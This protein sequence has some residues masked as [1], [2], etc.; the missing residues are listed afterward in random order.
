MYNFKTNYKIS[1]QLPNFNASTS[2]LVYRKKGLLLPFF[3]EIFH[4]YNNFVVLAS[5]TIIC[6]FVFALVFLQWFLQ[7]VSI[8]DV[9]LLWGN[10]NYSSLLINFYNF[11]FYTSWT[12]SILFS[13]LNFIDLKGTVNPN[14]L[15]LTIIREKVLL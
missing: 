8:Y 14:F 4:L 15:N 11:W 12:F 3:I 13:F 5:T 2:K 9:A 1:K 10:I 7:R 6:H